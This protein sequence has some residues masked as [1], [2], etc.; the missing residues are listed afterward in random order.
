MKRLFVFTL[1]AAALAGCTRTEVVPVPVGGTDKTVIEHKDTT[2]VAP[3]PAPAPVTNVKVT[4][5]ST[6]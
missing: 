5:Q 2:V 3:A 4:T 1:L 6:P